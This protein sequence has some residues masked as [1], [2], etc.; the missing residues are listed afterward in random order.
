MEYSTYIVSSLLPLLLNKADIDRL[1][2]RSESSLEDK[3]GDIL[4]GFT[5]AAN[6]LSREFLGQPV[7][8]ERTFDFEHQIEERLREAGRRLVQ[9]VYN[10]AEPAAEA[11]PKHVHFEAS[12]YT[13]LQ[14]KTPQNA[15]A[16]FGQIRLWRV[17]YRPTDKSGDR[18][19]FPLALA[20]G[21]VHG[22]SPAL[23]ERAAALMGETGRTQ[24]TVLQRLKQDYGVGWGVKKLRQVTALIADETAAQ[25]QEVQV[26][27]LLALLKWRPAA[28]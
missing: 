22:A 4:Q 8:P 16:L 28:R 26:E 10:H 5:D 6:Q 3:I 24:K 11:L 17:G 9:A 14:R 19:I 25:R 15:W 20:L 2:P 1:L 21:L 7:D 23:A 18:T 27:K 12:M 13:R